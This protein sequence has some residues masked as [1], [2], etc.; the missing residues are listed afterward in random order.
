LGS[1]LIGFLWTGQ[2][3][4]RK[5][6]QRQFDRTFE[7]LTSWGVNLDREVLEVAY[8]NTR[9]VSSEYHAAAVKLLRIFA[10][11]LAMVSNQLVLQAGN[12]E[13]PMIAKAKE[14]IRQHH[15]DDLSL[16]QVAK[17]SNTSHYYFCKI[18]KQFT[19]LTFTQFLSRVRIESCTKL[20][21]NPH[22]R[23]SEVAYAVGF[24][25]LTHFNRVFQR[26]LGQSPTE[27]RLA[28]QNRRNTA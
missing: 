16:P 5:P 19:H 26:I 1:R 23:V 2:V 21:T 17:F 12:A 20:L 7:L 3:F 14:Y 11:H 15:A 27:Y 18:F 6:T 25:S 10:E 13:P 28:V 8:F 22:L 9:V 24:Q 4:R